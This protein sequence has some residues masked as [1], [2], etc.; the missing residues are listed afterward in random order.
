MGAGAI[1]IFTHNPRQWRGPGLDGVAIEDLKKALEAEPAIASI[2]T[3]VTYLVNLAS[4]DPDIY[5]RS[6]VSLACNL[7]AA[8]AIAASGAVLHPGSHKGAGFESCKARI[9]DGISWAFEH[10]G[11]SHIVGE[12]LAYRVAVQGQVSTLLL[13]NTAGAGGTVGR[14]FDELATLIEMLDSKSLSG[15]IGVCLDTQH[16]WASGKDYTSV[17]SADHV[18]DEFDQAIGLDK[19]ECLH[20]NDSKVPCGAMRDRHANIG[21]GMIGKQGLAALLGHPRLGSLTAILEVPGDGHGPD[22]NQVDIA[23]ETLEQGI[24]M[25]AGLANDVQPGV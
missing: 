17:P 25:R 5:D 7:A 2:V 21:E 20:L 3:H 18:I 23:R 16:L 24:A 22:R 9:V 12:Q 8:T 11:D 14:S 1:Q 6:R 19:L 4:L 13:E 15:R 10:A